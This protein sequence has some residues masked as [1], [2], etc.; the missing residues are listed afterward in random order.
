M[1]FF[2]VETL[3][4]ILISAYFFYCYITRKF[5][6]WKS[7]GVK[8]PKP[9]PFFGNTKD[10]SRAKLSMGSYFQDIYNE[11]IDEKMIGIFEGHVPGLVLRDPDL[12]K[13]VIIKDFSVFS[14]RPVF[15]NE[16]IEPLSQHLFAVKPSTWRPLRTKLSPA[17]TSGKLK[18]ML[19]LKLECL[20]YLQRN[21]DAIV[22]KGEPID[23]EDITT[24]FALDV[25]GTCA[26]GLTSEAVNDDKNL[27]RRMS[28]KVFRND[29]KTY[30][31]LRVGQ[32]PWLYNIIGRLFA[33]KDVEDFFIR[34]TIDVL[35][36]RQQHNV[37]R[38]DIID[39][40][41]DIKDQKKI[42]DLDITESF[43]ASQSLAFLAGGYETTSKALS[44]AM[45]ELALNQLIQE[46]LRREIK[47]V[48]ES[49]D[50]KITYECIKNMK[51][52]EAFIQ[53]T[54]RK[55]PPLMYLVRKSLEDYT[56]RG[57]DVTIPKNTKVFIPVYGIQKHPDN[58]PRPEVFDPERFTEKSIK[59]RHPMHFLPFGDGPR[60]CIAFRF[61]LNEIKLYLIKIIQNYLVD[62]CDK[63]PPPPYP[64]NKSDEMLL[65]PDCKIFVKLVPIST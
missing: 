60:N 61:A 46:K 24:R 17:F 9:I 2:T 11:Y 14:A 35:E 65:K 55:Y 62:V 34:F 6:F 18:N 13:D 41:L 7:R 47:E 57:T 59:S 37:R 50:G 63:T 49:T 45:Y 3:L 8:G 51:Y 36:Y 29:L 32:I 44:N 12:I 23:C 26:F 53:E 10:V 33:D 16:K 52:L 15:Y 30:L 64:L 39:I 54:L 38:D 43:L 1:A 31:R 21:L 56:F 5:D 22:K 4:L 48:L 42:D 27:F 40:L 20:E 28:R 58:Y 25:I 19:K